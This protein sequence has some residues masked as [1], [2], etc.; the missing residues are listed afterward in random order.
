MLIGKAMKS[1]AMLALAPIALALAGCSETPE[2]S[3]AK[4][5]QEFAAHDY[6]AARVHLLSA[7]EASPN[8]KAMLLLQARTLLALGDG[9]GAQATL[10]KLARGPRPQGE[11][12][13][14]SAEAALLRNA[15][16]AVPQILEG[17]RTAEGER[18]LALAALV[19][20]D[21]AGASDHFQKAVAGPGNARAF[22]DFARFKLMAGDLAGADELIAKAVKT[23]PDGIDTLLV[24]GEVA[25]R[26]G[27]LARA[28]DYYDRAAR[29]YPLSIA[30]L[31]GKAAVLGDLG[32]LDEVQTLLDRAGSL[33]PRDP[34][35]LF[36]RARLAADRK[37]WK[38]VR[39]LVQPAEAKLAPIDPL[40]QIYGEA[41]LRMGES[42]Q[43][44]AQ[45]QPIVRALPGNRPAALLLAEAQLASRSAKAAMDT[46]RPL[47]DSPLVQ[48]AELAL[49]AKAAEAAG[50]PAAAGY[51]ARSRQAQPRAM[52]KDLADG[53]IAMRS[54][55]WAGAAAAYERLLASSDGK[56][57][58]ALNNLAYA[59]LML[60]NVAKAVDYSGRALKLA[61]D[62]PSVLDTAGWARFKAGEGEQ[63]KSLLRRAAQQA[64]D[65]VTI[66]SHLAEAEGAKR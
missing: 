11:L 15:A 50:D 52:I 41:F 28:L 2:Q 56:N 3:F 14:L 35:I 66:R 42:E 26:H 16:K 61:P 29:I 20:G 44:I 58:L 53:D 59:Q 7:L 60:G 65:N 5:Q 17:T 25:V 43:A 12:A 24:G 10:E 64:P 31:T 40:R 48:P 47:V 49:M 57:V 18:L 30:A 1:T 21:R 34:S 38:G 23:A 45:L 51:A 63:A 36:L 6:A 55:N 27:D 54:G 33:A 37:D 46:L 39:A 8:D 4:A 32:R 62:N 22:A 13:E 19:Q 9:D